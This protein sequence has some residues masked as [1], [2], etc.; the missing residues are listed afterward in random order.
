[1]AEN[2]I[3]PATDTVNVKGTTKFGLNQ[4]TN[5]TPMWATWVFRIEFLLNKT[6]MIWVAATASI[7]K[8]HLNEMILY[9]SLI[10]GFFW[11]IG[12]FIGISKDQ[13][14]V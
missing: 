6:F 8:E 14:A 9:A 11:G 13:I 1:M 12:K 7:P 2:Q 4:V 10:D 5:P 3:Q